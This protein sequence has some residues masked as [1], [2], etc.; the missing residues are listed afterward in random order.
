MSLRESLDRPV[1][2]YMSE[3]FAQVGGQD[4]VAVAARAMQKSGSTEAIVVKDGT[5]IGIV[6]ER[7]ILYKV[8]ASGSD[9]SK[10]AVRDVMSSPVQTVEATSKVMEAI[11]QMSKLGLRRLGVTQNGKLVGLVTQRA[12]VTGS[13][14]QSVPLPELAVPGQLSCPYCDATMKSKEELSKHIDQVHLGLGL[15]EGDTSKW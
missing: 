6:T 7:D 12:M 14:H 3:R 2:D 9:P 4:T 10:V 1:S 13:L 8:V 5:P 11:S 15:L